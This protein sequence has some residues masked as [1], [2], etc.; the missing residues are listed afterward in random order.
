MYHVRSLVLANF[1]HARLIIIGFRR[2][3]CRHVMNVLIEQPSSES[4]KREPV[5]EPVSR[6]QEKA[7]W[8]QNEALGYIYI[9]ACT[10]VLFH[11]YVIVTF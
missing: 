4:R 3:E 10:S 9:Y 8:S 2:D 6:V 11:L 1:L 5:V 7:N